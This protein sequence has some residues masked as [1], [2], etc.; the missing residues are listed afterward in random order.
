MKN[1]IKLFVVTGLIAGVLTQCNKAGNTGTGNPGQPE[2]SLS[3]TSI[4]R[5]EP[6]QANASTLTN[7][8]FI[9]WTVTPAQGNLVSAAKNNSTILFSTS[10]SYKVTA[11]YYA[12][13]GSAPIDSVS[14]PIV[15]VDSVYVPPVDTESDTLSLAGDQLI[16]TPQ[17][18][19]DSGFVFEVR[20]L[21]TYNCIPYFIGY[22]N[23]FDGH[24]IAA[25]FDY[26]SN[27]INNDCGGAM[28][29]AGV[30]L[31]Y[32]LVAD[33]DYVIDIEFNHTHY[34]GSVHINGPTYTF[35]WPYTS[36]VTMSPLQIQKQ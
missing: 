30:Y 13:S 4:M 29:H 26:V 22:Y 3:K 16:L 34:Q 24:T 18:L 36:G 2:L 10:G 5:G 14:S 11:S 21:N 1:P 7:T 12:D 35:T 23:G 6:L 31:F 8:S 33:G 28:N 27:H 20:T 32:G 19:Y 17:A 9:K 25:G 15:V